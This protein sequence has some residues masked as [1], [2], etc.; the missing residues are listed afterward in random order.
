[1][2]TILSGPDTVISAIHELGVQLGFRRLRIDRSGRGGTDERP[3]SWFEVGYGCGEVQVRFS[4]SDA[5]PYRAS[6]DEVDTDEVA[7]RLCWL[8]DATEGGQEGSLIMHTI[9]AER[10]VRMEETK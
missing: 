1:M 10:R 7:A 9:E 6:W 4:R 5:G 3:V 8:I 2:S